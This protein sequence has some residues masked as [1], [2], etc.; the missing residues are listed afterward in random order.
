MSTKS[1]INAPKA[2]ESAISKLLDQYASGPIQFSGTD[3]ALYERHLLFDTVVNL[4]DA[5][6]RERFEAFARGAKI[7][8]AGVLFLEGARRIL[9][10]VNEATARA[11]R[12]ARGQ[13]G[14]LRVRFTPSFCP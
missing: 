9:Q 8:S 1:A 6:P 14:T 10:H 2:A 5:G 7:S 4:K 13:S 11:Q 3:N 12:V